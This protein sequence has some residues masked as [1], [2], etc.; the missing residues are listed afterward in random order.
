[1]I[2]FAYHTKK[3]Y[4]IVMKRLIA[5]L[6]ILLIAAMALSLQFLPGLI[7]HTA[8]AATANFGNTTIGT[9]TTTPGAGYK[10]GSVYNL[11]QA[12][13]T[14]SFSWYTRGGSSTQKMMPVVYTVDSSGNPS[15]LVSKGAEVTIAAQKAAGWVTSTLPAV[16]LAKGNYLLGLMSGPTGTQVFDYMT[17]TANAAYWNPNTY[18]SPTTVWGGINHENSAYSFY[19]TY[20]PS[21]VVSPPANTAAPGISGTSQIGQALTS[22]TGSWTNSPTSYSYQ[23]QRCVGTTCS[24]IASAASS[25]YALISADVGN[26]IKVVVTATNSGGSGQ[27]SSAVTGTIQ[28]APATAPTN[29]TLPSVSGMAQ[30]GQILTTNLGGWNGNPAPTLSVQWQDCQS[31]VCTNITGATAAN[32]TVVVADGNNSLRVVVTAANSAGSS[33]A[34]SAPTSVVAALVAPANQA[35]PVI[36]GTAQAGQTLTATKGTWAGNPTPALGIQWQS[37]NGTTCTNIAGATNTSY[38]PANSDVGNTLQVVVTAQNSVDTA[39]ASSVPTAAVSAQPVVTTGTLGITA[40]GTT[41]SAAGSGYKFGTISS[42]S[43]AV[44]AKDFKWYVRGG[45]ASQ[46]FTPIIYNVDLMGNPYQLVA[47]GA[48]VTVNVNQPAGWVTVNLPANTT[49]QPGRYLLGLL[50]GNAGSSAYNYYS[51][52]P[53][54]GVWNYNGPTPSQNWGVVNTEAQQWSFYIDYQ[55]VGPVIAPTNQTPSS[56]SGSPISGQTLS[57]STGTWANNPTS[58]TY[59]W[60]GCNNGTCTNI[61][62]ATQ[63][64]YVL[65][66][67][68]VGNTIKAV[69]IASNSAGSATAVSAPTATI[70]QPTGLTI[71]S[72]TKYVIDPNPPGAIIEKVLA[73][74]NGDGKLDAV[75]GAEPSPSIPGS[76]GGIYWYEYP[77]SGNISDPWIKHTILGGGNAYEDMQITDVDG[78]GHVDIVAS[79]NGNIYWYKNP[80]T[81]TGNWTENLIGNGFGEN[82]MRIVDIDGDGKLDVITSEYAFF[83]NSPTS[84]TSVKIAASDLGAALLDIGSG[85]GAIN[86]VTTSPGPGFQIGWY[87]NPREV[88]GSARTDAWTFFPIGPS[89]TG[90]SQTDTMQTGDFNNDGRMDVVAADSEDV[91][92]G[93]RWF[94][95]PTD[96]TQPWTLHVIDSTYQF[97]HKVQVADIDGNG[98]LDLVTAEQDQAAQKRVSVFYND[99]SGNFTQQVLSNGAGHNITLGDI[100][101]DGDIDIFNSGHGYFGA[102]HPLEIYINHRF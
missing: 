22:S 64:S 30:I 26:T 51:P 90:R 83:Q 36:S 21:V 33:T 48:Q 29:Q 93:L 7:N 17:P 44:V 15:T 71:E 19:V 56:I 10:F 82:T 43:V 49:L 69:I 31:S 80:G 75:V 28:P 11:S 52:V 96:R 63:N 53:G 99:G 14:V 35:V 61:V 45:T 60:Q 94:E 89:A 42:L 34:N 38:T 37:C 97:A 87:R 27:A 84:W 50:P 9:S 40:I 16:A 86:L 46:S 72:F 25:T 62:G 102:A 12:G 78:D 39:T 98:T 24:N 92:T 70:S 73:D 55:T 91:P 88:G 77:A 5:K 6:S 95:A 68:D 79:V 101:G 4:G 18:G 1:M 2:N 66:V 76:V 57:A 47:T 32:Y 59:Q 100:E 67:S 74:V 85:K 58:Y 65:A 8:Q 3:L 41:S 81:S 23:W 13:T 20:T 54:T